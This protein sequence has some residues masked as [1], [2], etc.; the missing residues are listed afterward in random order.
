MQ[1]NDIRVSYKLWG[2]ILG[3]LLVLPTLAS[4]T[5]WRFA[6]VVDSANQQIAHAEQTITDAVLWRGIVDANI[7][8]TLAAI[9]VADDATAQLF[10]SRQEAGSVASAELQKRITAN[11]ESDADKQALAQISQER[12]KVLELLKKI[13]QA[14]AEGSTQTLVY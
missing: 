2:T 6:H 4:L 12:S 10:R 11:A 3:L 1:I 14:R 9:L 5:L 8:R 7:E 13:P